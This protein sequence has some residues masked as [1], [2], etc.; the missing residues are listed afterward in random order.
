MRVLKNPETKVINALFEQNSFMKRT[1]E[2]YNLKI[3]ADYF[4][5]KKTTIGVVM[6]GFVNP[7]VNDN[8][9]VSNMKN[10]AGIVDST[11]S[12][13]GDIKDKWKNGSINLNAR[14]QFD[15]TGREITTDFDYVRYG[16]NSSQYFYNTTTYPG[17]SQPANDE[18]LRGLLPVDVNIYSA[19]VDYAHP[20]RNGL[21]LETG[22]KSSYVKTDNTA[23]YD[24]LIGGEWTPDYGK[25]NHFQYTENVNAAYVNMNKQ[26]KKFGFQLGLRF[27]NTYYKGHQ[28]GNPERKDSSFSRNYNNLFPTMF[29]S[30]AANKKNQFG[31]NFGRRIDRPA[32]QDLNPFL[33]FLDKFTY[34]SG[35]PYL[36]PQ[37]SNNIELSHTFN[38]FLTTT[39]NYSH[40]KD[41]FAETFEQVGDATIIV[42]KGNI[43]KRDNAGIAVSAQVPVKK[44]WTA[45]LYTNLNYNKF[46]GQLYGEKLDVEA[47]TALVNVNNQFKFNKGWSAELSGFYRTKGVEG[48]IIIKPMGQVSVGVGKQIMKGKGTVKFNVRDLFYTQVVHGNINFKATEATF[49]NSRDSRVANISFVYR[50]GKPIKGAQA[51][52]NIGGAGDEQKRVNVGAQ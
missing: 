14:H 20:F 4:L 13:K 19:K 36:Q 38:N 40:T 33:F 26:V 47:T 21:K 25:T 49:V 30:Y 31:L 24:N 16:S 22:I 32:Y 11:I 6:S 52:K 17:N 28:S 44:W 45:I 29:I 34:G 10:E 2:N 46:S 43:G 42:R 39:L 1:S 51:R 12:A 48:Q 35:N 18:I 37:Y 27:E 5:S 50:F 7:S 3:G 23:Q 41:L 9:I 15:S 8:S